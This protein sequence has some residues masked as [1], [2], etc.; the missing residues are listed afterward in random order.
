MSSRDSNRVYP[1]PQNKPD[2]ERLPLEKVT[3]HKPEMISPNTNQ[4]PG[5][6]EDNETP[7]MTTHNSVTSMTKLKGITPLNDAKDKIEAIA[8]K[9]RITYIENYQ[10]EPETI[11]EDV[12]PREDIARLDDCTN[13]AKTL[14]NLE[15]HIINDS[16]ETKSQ[17]TQNG[18]IR[19]KERADSV[20]TFPEGMHPSI[21]NIDA[22]EKPLEDP[23]A[24]KRNPLA[25]FT[26]TKTDE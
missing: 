1:K 26:E 15:A 21:S 23:R 14:R 11:E 17:G 4:L 24:K 20:L 18:E 19:R 6:I 12:S 9:G 25:K 3:D 2:I 22:H 10:Y 16:E 8:A 7:T 5:I 13:I